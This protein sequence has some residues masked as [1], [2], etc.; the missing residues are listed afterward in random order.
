MLTLSYQM[1]SIKRPAK[2][3]NSNF[4]DFDP[5]RYSVKKTAKLNR[6]KDRSELRKLTIMLPRNRD[7]DSSQSL[8]FNSGN[9]YSCRDY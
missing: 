3:K 6:S 8:T 7:V 1:S 2:N 5:D 4:A 9:V